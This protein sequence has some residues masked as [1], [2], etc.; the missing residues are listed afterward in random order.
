MRHDTY[1]CNQAALPALAPVPTWPSDSA[2][3]SFLSAASTIMIKDQLAL[4]K[5]PARATPATCT[6][7]VGLTMSTSAAI[8]VNGIFTKNGRPAQAWP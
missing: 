5:P 2:V 6:Q 3:V 1:P 7:L 4:S 8:P